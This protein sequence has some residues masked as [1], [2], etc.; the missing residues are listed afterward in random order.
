MRLFTPTE[1]VE[2]ATYSGKALIEQMNA[3]HVP[4][5]C[6]AMWGMGQMGVALKGDDTGIVYIDL[7]LSDIVAERF[8]AEHFQRAF[9]APV[10]PADITNAAYVLC[11]HEHQDH[12]DPLT[13]APIAQASPEARFVITG[14]SQGILDEA[15]IAPGRRIV[16]PTDQTIQIGSARLTAIPAAHYALERDDAR[17]YRFF[18]FIIEWNGVTFY[19]SGDTLAYPGYLERMKAQPRADVAMVAS[20]G[21]DAYRDS[22]NVTGNLMPAEAAWLAKELGWDMLIGGHN[23]LYTWNTLTAGALPDDLRRLNPRQK[24]HVLQPGELFLYV[25]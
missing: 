4:P 14:W 21:R 16:P 17:G 9:P 7:C 22:Y 15:D 13:L 12:T 24:Y 3:L 19:H 1:R 2:M 23:D 5:G 6:L 25:R 20:N 18:G 10:D 11:S 8:D